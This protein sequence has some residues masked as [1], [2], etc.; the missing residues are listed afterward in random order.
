MGS[1]NVSDNL[2]SVLAL[3]EP[4]MQRPGQRQNGDGWDGRTLD[5]S[6]DVATRCLCCYVMSI[7]GHGQ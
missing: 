4:A 1:N 6:E 7:R 5:I 2:P 3:F